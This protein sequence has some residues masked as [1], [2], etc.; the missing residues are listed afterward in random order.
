MTCSA[1]ITV[2]APRDVD[3]LNRSPVSWVTCDRD[4]WPEPA[5]DATHSGTDAYGRTWTWFRN[6]SG[7]NT[8]SKYEKGSLPDA[9]EERPLVR[10]E[11]ALDEE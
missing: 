8:V 11:V 9:P 2:L 6:Q 4:H 5:R 10:R 7:S 3:L 1:A